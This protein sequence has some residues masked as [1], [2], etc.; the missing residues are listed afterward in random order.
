MFFLS[1]S[2]KK[3]LERNGRYWAPSIEELKDFAIS[4]H[5]KPIVEAKSSFITGEFIMIYYG[6]PSPFFITIYPHK[7]LTAAKENFTDKKIIF[8]QTISSVNI[9]KNDFLLGNLVNTE[10]KRNYMIWAQTGDKTVLVTAT[11]ESI[12]SEAKAVQN[13]QNFYE[14]FKIK[15]VNDIAR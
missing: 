7:S 5:E 9:E 6:D 1:N 13:L 15:I 8:S 3:K 4:V 12:L 11:S 10:G 14:Q 2:A